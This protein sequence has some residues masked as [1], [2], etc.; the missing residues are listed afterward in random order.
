MKRDK[1][2]DIYIIPLEISNTLAAIFFCLMLIK[3]NI[4]IIIGFVGMIIWFVGV[5]IMFIVNIIV[6]IMDEKS[7][8]KRWKL[9]QK[10][11]KEL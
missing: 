10:I 3:N 7:M 2:G 11:K 8:K 9:N 4:T 5:T 6:G 1:Y